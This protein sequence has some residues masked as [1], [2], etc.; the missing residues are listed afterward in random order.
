MTAKQKQ[1]SAGALRQE[2]FTARQKEKGLKLYRNVWGLP[3]HEA[4]VKAYVARLNKKA[5]IE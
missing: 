1:K 2:A 5:G 4:Q 3:E